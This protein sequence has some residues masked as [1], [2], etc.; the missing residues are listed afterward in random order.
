MEG[1]GGRGWCICWSVGV[2]GTFGICILSR[3]GVRMLEKLWIRM[4]WCS[5]EGMGGIKGG[6]SSDVMLSADR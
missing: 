2:M 5:T 4:L 6:I 3:M 1:V